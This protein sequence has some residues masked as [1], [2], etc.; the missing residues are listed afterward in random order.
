VRI[1]QVCPYAW[2]APGGVQVHVR[3]LSA[4][5]RARGHEV[6]ILAPSLRPLKEDGVSIVGRALRI[7]YQGTVAPIC[8]TPG[9]IARIGREL[10]AFRPDLVHAHEPLSPSTG[11]FATLR[12]PAP[13]V[14]TFHAFAE[15]SRLIQLASPLLRIVWRRLTARV[16]VSKAAA[17]FMDTRFGGGSA[18]RIVPNGVD[19]ELFAKAQPADL[20]GGRRI[21][22]VGRL[23]RQKGLPVAVRAFADL[24]TRLPDVHLV[25]AGDGAERGTVAALSPEARERVVML[26]AVPHEKLPAY[27]AACDLLVAPALG[28]ESFGIVLVEAMA[29]GVPVVASRIPGYDE[30][31]RDGIDGI[32]VPPNDPRALADAVERLLGDPALSGRLAD[33]GRG[34]ASEFSWDHVTDRLEELYREVAP[35]T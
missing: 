9:S 15:R 25:V 31:V 8:F 22:W 24:A 12:S 7:P 14:G 26:G 2:D 5:L 1:V 13:V 29:A 35:S 34:R 28:Q 32:L 11:M 18:T 6:L 3:Q 17:S 30:V 33:A 4:N 20:P 21:L 19:V 23:D 27:H 10:R 16:A